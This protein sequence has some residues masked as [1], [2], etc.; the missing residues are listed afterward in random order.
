VCSAYAE[1]KS[2]NCAAKQKVFTL[3]IGTAQTIIALPT[4]VTS[5]SLVPVST[6]AGST[7]ITSTI[8]SSS[9]TASPKQDNNDESHTKRNIAIGASIGG[10]FGLAA[11]AALMYCCCFHR[12]RDS[13]SRA[14][15]P[16]SFT[17]L[18]A[19]GTNAP[20]SAIPAVQDPRPPPQPKPS[21]PP[22]GDGGPRYDLYDDGE[23]E[24]ATDGAAVPTS[25]T[26]RPEHL[27]AADRD[28]AGVT[29]HAYV[30]DSADTAQPRD[31]RP[32]FDASESYI[33]TYDGS[34]ADLLSEGDRPA[35]GRVSPLH[36]G[37]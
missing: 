23:T 26:R 2:A 6:A 21:S 15:T 9:A 19:P 22:A 25:I 37:K 27:E 1:D 14:S 35:A 7:L 8:P 24:I 34:R 33:S 12:R 30:N 20:L 3:P 11:A 5:T 31:V 36:G 4:G 18:E 16:D 10:F 13:L 32:G 29:G 17:K 28:L